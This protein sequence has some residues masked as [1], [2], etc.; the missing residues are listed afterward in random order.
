[1]E[2]IDQNA[3]RREPTPEEK[4]QMDNN[5]IKLSQIF[6]DSKL[7]W[8]LDGALNISLM[9]GEYIGIHKDTDISIEKEELEQANQQLGKSGYGLFLSH[10]KDPNGKKLMERV[11]PNLSEEEAGHLVVAAV[12]D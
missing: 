3:E 12:D 11:G 4:T 6:G 2:H 9:K 8:Q 10:E 5:L 7:S 1:M